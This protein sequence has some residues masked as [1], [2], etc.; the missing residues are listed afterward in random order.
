MRAVHRGTFQ[1]SILCTIIGLRETQATI[2]VNLY[3]DFKG[4]SYNAKREDTTE[5]L[6]FGHPTVRGLK[7]IVPPHA[8]PAHVVARGAVMEII[9][10]YGSVTFIGSAIP[11]LIPESGARYVE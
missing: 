2:W 7:T 8:N 9:A 1:Q 3:Q 4:R 11:I 6:P 10:S 5:V